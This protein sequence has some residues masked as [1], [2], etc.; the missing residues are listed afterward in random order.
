MAIVP[1]PEQGGDKEIKYIEIK[2]FPTQNNGSASSMDE[3]LSTQD[4]LFYVYFSTFSNI[5]Y[6]IK[7]EHVLCT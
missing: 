6:N 2:D 3:H 1:P 7:T 5:F 4:R